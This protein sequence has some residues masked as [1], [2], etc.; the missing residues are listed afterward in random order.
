M[1]GG[2]S[3]RLTNDCTEFETFKFAEIVCLNFEIV[4]HIIKRQLKFQNRRVLELEE[5]VALIMPFVL[6]F[7]LFNLLNDICSSQF[8]FASLY[9]DFCFSR[10]SQ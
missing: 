9:F 5:A 7:L 10:L 6:D 8:T 3:A 4:V 1:G 2:F